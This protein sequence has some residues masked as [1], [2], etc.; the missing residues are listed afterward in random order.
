MQ[1]NHQWYESDSRHHWFERRR[2]IIISQKHVKCGIMQ[3][4]LYLRKSVIRI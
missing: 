1:G 4:C 3:L 2:L